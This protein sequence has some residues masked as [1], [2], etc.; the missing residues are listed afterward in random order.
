M[1]ANVILGEELGLYRAM[2]DGQPVTADELAAKTGCNARL[3]REWL[4][5]QAASGYMEH[6]DGRFRLPAEQAMALANE[7]SPVYVA[8]GASVLASMFLDKDK[9]VKAMR[10][11]G[12]PVLG[13]P[14]SVPVLAAPSA[15]SAPATAPTSCPQWL[16]ALDGVVGEA[17]ARRQGRRRRLRPRRLDRRDGARRSRTRASSA[18]TSTQPSI[19][20][21]RQ[22]A[23]GGRRRR[24]RQFDAATRQ[25]LSRRTT[26]TWSASSTACTTWA[27]RSARR[28]TRT[29]R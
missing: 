23:R 28:A 27:I 24:A 22:R 7:D 29:R 11:D 13:R 4:S 6:A 21:A 20:T 26:T 1:L 12:A 9:I 15:S 17:R 16:P 19:E 14:S 8:G 5:A 3:V 10:G 25:G 18:S 2:A